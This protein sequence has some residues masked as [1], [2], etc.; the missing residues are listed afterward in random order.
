MKTTKKTRNYHGGKL[1]HGSFGRGR[2]FVKNC[3][4]Y[5]LDVRNYGRKLQKKLAGP[6]PYAPRPRLLTRVSLG[7]SLIHQN[8]VV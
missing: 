4:Q 2:S 6:R 5:L 3:A 8:F 1:P 7:K